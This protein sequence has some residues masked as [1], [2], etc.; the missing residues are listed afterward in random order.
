MISGYKSVCCKTY[1]LV[2]FIMVTAAFNMNITANLDGLI[3]KN[4]IYATTNNFWFNE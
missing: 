1:C 4:N 3:G 2:L